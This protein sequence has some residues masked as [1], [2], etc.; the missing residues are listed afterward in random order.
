LAAVTRR[1][2][3]HGVIRLAVLLAL[4]GLAATV[5]AMMPGWAYLAMATIT[6][7]LLVLLF[8]AMHEAS[9]MTAFR[10]GWLNHAVTHLVGLLLVL[11]PRWFTYFHMA[12]HQHT[13]DPERDPELASP[14]PTTWRGYLW[15]LT[16]VMVWAS[17]LKALFRNAAGVNTD[18]FI[19]TSQRQGIRREALVM[20]A[21]YGGVI[22]ISLALHSWAFLYIW[23]IPALL[24]Q[25]FLRAYLMAEHGGCGF[26]P[27]MLANS[28]TTLTGLPI[29]L[30]A[31]NM[32][33]HAEHHSLPAV[34]F[35]QLPAL[36][37]HTAPHITH[38]TPGYRQV[39][40]DL[41]AKLR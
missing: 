26:G 7:V 5:T 25:P 16:G 9:H 10:T 27:N 31:W 12:H 40:Q 4:L 22:L 2:N 28:R 34:P 32:P 24:G 21:I 30:L 36:H 39:H 14:K 6:G 3:A 20:L 38:L 1:T 18:G 13:Q 23:V 35:H 41:V 17:Q 19:A 15:H 29:R 37:R 11:P 33:F 8:T